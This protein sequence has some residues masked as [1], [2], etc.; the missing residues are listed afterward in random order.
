MDDLKLYSSSEKGLHH[1]L[2]VVHSYSTDI[3]MEFGIDKCASLEMRMGRVVDMGKDVD[4]IDG[5][6]IHHLSAEET[7]TKLE[8]SSRNKVTAT[9]TF[10]IPVLVY[11]FGVLHWTMKEL[12]DVDRATRKTMNLHRSLHPKSSVQRL[13]LPRDEGGRGLLGVRHLHD[14]V[15]IGTAI[16]LL[17]NGDDP[18]LSLVITHERVGG[19]SFLFQTAER[20]YHTRNFLNSY[21]A[22][23]KHCRVGSGYSGIKDVYQVP[24]MHDDVQ[25]SFFLA[26]TLKYLYLLFSDDSLLPL[27]EWVFNTEA[28]PLPIRGR[29][30]HYF[31]KDRDPRLPSLGD[32]S[33]SGG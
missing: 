31:S 25:Q 28:H 30:P 21:Q 16:R 6:V 5:T 14:R 22:L 4:L 7:Y 18:L 20:V 3:G 9:N 8:L 19:G 13:Y 2:S 23:E 32:L 12:E 24:P 1:A 11:T 15:T 26:E 10:A 27:D 29:N 33:L 17:T